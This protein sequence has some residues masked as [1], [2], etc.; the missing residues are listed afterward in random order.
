MVTDFE[1]RLRQ[2]REAKSRESEAN[3]RS[4]LERESERHAELATRFDRRERI[5]NTILELA[6]KFM[7]VVTTF[8]RTKSFF[9]G[10]Y[11]IQISAD[12]VVIGESGTM[13]KLFSRITFLIDTHAHDGSIGVRCK[14]TVRNRDL[15]SAQAM[16][17][18]SDD[19]LVAFRGFADAQFIEFAGEYFAGS[20][21]PARAR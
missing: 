20:N 13:R 19:A 5:E 8:Q 9:E 2:I 3:K 12:E 21:S 11:E 7:E 15:E 17:D 6:D 10:M 4:Q 16:V 14:K 1:E 18:P